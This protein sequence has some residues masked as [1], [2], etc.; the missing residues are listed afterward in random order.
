MELFKDKGERKRKSR[1]G[2]WGKGDVENGEWPCVWEVG[3]VWWILGGV[4]LDTCDRSK[5]EGR[6]GVH[7]LGSY[8]VILPEKNL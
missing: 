1:F 8:I 7:S 4:V 5:G 3:D 2:C 6:A